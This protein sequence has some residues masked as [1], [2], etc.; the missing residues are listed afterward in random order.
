[1][2]FVPLLPC[3]TSMEKNT[4]VGRGQRAHEGM[5][6]NAK[7]HSAFWKEAR[8]NTA[9]LSSCGQE[10]LFIV[11][12]VSSTVWDCSISPW[13]RSLYQMHCQ[14]WMWCCSATSVHC[15]FLFFWTLD[16]CCNTFSNLFFFLEASLVWDE[17]CPT[18]QPLL[19]DRHYDISFDSRQILRIS[20]TFQGINHILHLCIVLY[21][22]I[23]IVYTTKVVLVS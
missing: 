23:H 19:H 1:M 20:F 10:L 8:E 4:K 3:V 22:T 9:Q 12:M 5:S 6:S 7:G 14:I 16:Y 2:C 11:L 17:S 18:N 13:V 21:D 15:L